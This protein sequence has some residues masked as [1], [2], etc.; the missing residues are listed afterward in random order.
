MCNHGYTFKKAQDL[1]DLGFFHDVAGD[2]YFLTD[3]AVTSF[4]L[5]C[6]KRK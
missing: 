1:C 6:M 3:Y 2:L 4:G 5:G